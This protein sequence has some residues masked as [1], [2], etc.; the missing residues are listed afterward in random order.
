MLRLGDADAVAHID[1]RPEPE[2]AGKL[3]RFVGENVAIHV[4]RDDDVESVRRADEQGCGGIDDHFVEFD[5][6]EIG[7]NHS[8]LAQEQPIGQFEH[9]RLVNRRHLFA[10][11]AGE[12]EGRSRDAGGTPRGNLPNRQRHVLV[13]HEFA[14]AGVHIAV[15][16]EA[17]GVLADDDEVH[18]PAQNGQ[19]VAGPAGADIRIEIERDAQRA[20]RG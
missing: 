15:G 7:G 6:R 17:F 10:A 1:R 8:H 4:S 3:G 14:A 2:T 11:P 18:R 13:R 5:V 19:P 12:F 20:R 9:V 16:I